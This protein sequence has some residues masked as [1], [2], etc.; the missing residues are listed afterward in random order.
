MQLA[1]QEAVVV[2]RGLQSALPDL[3]LVDHGVEGIGDAADVGWHVGAVT[4]C[5]GVRL[6]RARAAA[7]MP[8]SQRTQWRSIARR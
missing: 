7:S 5:A 6:E 4:A 8:R 1:H 3:L 2:E